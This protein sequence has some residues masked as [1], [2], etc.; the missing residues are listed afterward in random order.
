MLAPPASGSPRGARVPARS[1]LLPPKSNPA[2]RP[3]I[4]GT[5]G[6]FP[7]LRLVS[8]QTPLL[9]CSFDGS[10]P[11]IPTVVRLDF[12]SVD[13]CK[14]T[15]KAKARIAIFRFIE[16]WYNSGRRHSV[17]G[18]ISLI[19]FALNVEISEYLRRWTRQNCTPKNST[20][21]KAVCFLLLFIVPGLA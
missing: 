4:I 9:A 10:V 20:V 11:L 2:T 7:P 15:T 5:A 3:L 12:L 14:F 8:M 1:S 17:I 16:G 19:N 6:F 18:Y 13:R 21:A